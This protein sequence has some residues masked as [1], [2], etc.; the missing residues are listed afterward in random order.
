MGK[1]MN[2]QFSKEAQMANKYIRKYLTSLAMKKMQIK[3][4]LR[5]HLNNGYHQENKH[6]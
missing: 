4:F 6:W 1:R 3:T 5:F 2:R